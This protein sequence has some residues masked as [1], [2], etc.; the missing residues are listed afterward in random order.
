MGRLKIFGVRWVLPLALWALA[1]APIRAQSTAPWAVGASRAE[2]LVVTLATIDPAEPIYTWW[3]HTALIIED[4]RLQESRLYNYGLFT[5]DQDSFVR[6][7]VMGR[8]WFQVGAARPGRELEYNA[9]MNRSIRLQTLD[10]P[11]AKR[12]G[13]A[14]FLETNILPENRVYLYDHYY[15]NCATRV[16]DVIDQAVDGQLF[17]ATNEPAELTLREATRRYTARHPGMDW[18]LMFLMSDSIDR[19]VTRWEQMFLP[20]ELERYV[21][22]LRYVDAQGDSRPLAADERVYHEA[23]GVAPIPD[24]AAPHWPWGLAVGVL[25][26]AA[27][28][29]LGYWASR[30]GGAAR[31][32]FGLYNA[33]AGLA[34]GIPGSALFFMSKFTDHWVTYSN[35]NL[36]L[37]NPLALLLVPLGIALAAG[38]KRSRRWLPMA[39]YFLSTVAVVY[40]I[41]KALP[42]FRQDNWLAVA[43]ILPVL[44]GFSEG[45]FLLRLGR[46]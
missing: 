45:F 11:P 32:L 38:G 10:L 5:F 16:R 41:L 14:E 20:G 8:L 35:E 19:P 7:F 12:L 31:V 22:S 24:R 30:R 15:D 33:L 29:G 6:N 3:G 27:A 37:A 17:A 34:L 28:A 18:L 1:A 36:F 4:T 21:G 44:L 23:S 42:V 25:L 43:T 13:V 46:R 9:R 40:L 39:W 2:D 26:G